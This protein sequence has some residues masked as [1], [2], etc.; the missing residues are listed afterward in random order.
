[1]ELSLYQWEHVVF[2]HQDGSLSAWGHLGHGEFFPKSLAGEFVR[3]KQWFCNNVVQIK[4]CPGF[5]ARTEG[6][7]FI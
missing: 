7:R 4:Y 5:S 2:L 3:R 6:H 1:M